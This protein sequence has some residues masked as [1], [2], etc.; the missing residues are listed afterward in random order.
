MIKI[1]GI[2]ATIRK[3]EQSVAEQQDRV[4]D[5][6]LEELK[7]AT[8]VDTGEASRGWRREGN[9]LINEVEHIAQL[10]NGSSAQAPE[11][12]IE[13]TLMSIDGIKPNGVIVQSN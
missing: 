8:P 2:A 6:A 10:N 3:L 5:I 13:K 9:K 11:H 7:A 4:L 12:F 1:K